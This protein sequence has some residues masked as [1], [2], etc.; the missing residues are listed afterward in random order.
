[1]SIKINVRPGMQQLTDNQDTVEVSGKTVGECINQLIGQFPA[2]R[3]QLLDKDGG[4]L[5]Y[6][7]VYVNGKSS[8]PE[9]LVKQVKDGDELHILMEVSGG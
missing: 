2:V 6:I 1:M 5:N 8:Y 7:D 9:E 4:I 3:D